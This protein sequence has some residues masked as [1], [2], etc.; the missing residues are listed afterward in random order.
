MSLA[1]RL[2]GVPAIERDGAAATPPR[3]QKAWA[4]LAYLALSERPPT[5][6]E[7][8][9]LLFSTAN[10]PLGA[11]RWS[12]S[13]LRKAIEP[14]G[15]VGGDPVELRL[16]RDSDLD[17]GRLLAG[18]PL[19]PPAVDR[20]GR[21]LLEGLELGDSPAFESWLLV[22]RRRLA[23]AAEAALHERALAELAAGDHPGATDSAR[24][25]VGLNPFEENHQELLV[26]CLAAGGDREAALAQANACGELFRRELGYDPSPAVRRAADS[27]EP[28]RRE[29]S[30]QATAARG[31]LEAGR[32][33]ISAGATESGITT[34]REACA[35]A[36][37]SGDSALRAETLCALGMALVHVVRGWDG[38][39]AASLHQAVRLAERGGAREVA[40]TAHRELGWIGV[41]SGRREQALTHLAQAEQLAEGDEEIA[42]VLGVRGIHAS[43]TADYPEAISLLSESV[44]RADRAGDDRQTAY[45]A[46][47]LARARV[48][49]WDLDE[50]ARLAERSIAAAERARW[51]ALAPFPETV[52]AEVDRLRGRPDKAMEQ[53]QHAFTLGCQ[54]QDPCWESFAARGIG[55]VSASEG[56]AAEAGRWLEEARQRC[57]RWPDRYEWA[58]AY[59]LEAAV[60][61]AVAR[62]DPRAL[63]M[64][65]RL[66]EV[67]SRAR[68]RELV[69]RG[70]LHRARLGDSDAAPGAEL[71]AREID[72]P[73]LQREVAARAE[74]PIG[75]A[76]PG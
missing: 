20:L 38:E 6:R 18:S 14:D 10:D 65:A 55:L 12:L 25:A 51:L 48:L 53:F 46:G 57:T 36:A 26:R 5:R 45:S 21:D 32:A 24:R 33:A 63:D 52:R 15:V 19:D 23:A 58:H 4:L 62:E 50:A 66:V 2:L 42:A 69:V 7:L 31:L 74:A 75:A 37:R 11:L 59:V 13:Q 9:E 47:H 34:L 28:F 61:L 67:A 35:E 56:D 73:A 41:V 17:V 70:L 27:P 22:E 30:G 44:E 39:G 72:N 54:L 71:L 3:G 8:A 43:D 16:G 40:T 60:E 29:R 49:R 64:A 68:F 76:Q 1:I